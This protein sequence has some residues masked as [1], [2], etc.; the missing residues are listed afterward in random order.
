MT[1]QERSRRNLSPTKEAMAAM[2]L[3]G[4]DYSQQG[5][6]SMDFWDSLDIPRKRLCK[7]LVD[8]I[9]AANGRSVARG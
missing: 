9:L 1:E 7:K 3:Y 8:D 6:G 5:G 2:W 4:S